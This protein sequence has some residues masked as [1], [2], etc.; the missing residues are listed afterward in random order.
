LTD[1]LSGLI[2]AHHEK[3]I[4]IDSDC[5]NHAYAFAGGF[6]I[7]RGRF[8]DQHHHVGNIQQNVDRSHIA[9]CEDCDS[10]SFFLAL[11][12]VVIVVV[13]IVVVVVVVIIII[14]V[15]VIIIIIVV[16]LS[17]I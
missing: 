8:D 3:L 16:V 9:V 12:V 5:P 6:D 2:S 15:V 14:V 1:S 13:V 11:V 10:S 7:C 4:L 17:L